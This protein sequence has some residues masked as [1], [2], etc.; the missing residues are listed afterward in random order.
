MATY[1][2]TKR[3]GETH[4]NIAHRAPLFE[5]LKLLQAKKLAELVKRADAPP[6]GLLDAH[7]LDGLK[8]GGDAARAKAT[9]RR[10][11]SLVEDLR[12]LV[13]PERAAWLPF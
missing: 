8:D 7:D 6:A 11:R 4:R 1:E 12:K 13:G 10:A 2:R 3:R 9:R 5:A